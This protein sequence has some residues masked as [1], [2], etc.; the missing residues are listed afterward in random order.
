MKA[1][2]RF[3]N[4]LK[5]LSIHDARVVALPRRIMVLMMVMTLCLLVYAA[6]EYRIREAFPN[7]KGKP[8]SNPTTRWVFQFFSGIHL[9]LVGGTQQL[10]LNLNEHHLRLLK[11]LG[12]RYEK[13]YSENGEGVC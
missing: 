1:L 4:K 6:L 11:L 12:R 9:L 3:E 13:L 10:I 8:A 7:Q 2:S 5:I